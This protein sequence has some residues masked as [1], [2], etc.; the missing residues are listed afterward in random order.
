M[1]DQETL[2][3]LFK[4]SDGFLYWKSSNTNAVKAGGLAGS[5][6]SSGYLCVLVKNKLQLVHRV[7]FMMHNGYAPK[8]VDHIDGNPMNNKIENLRDAT[9]SQ[10]CWNSKTRT[11][12]SSG[13]KNVS[14]HSKS[15]KWLVRLRANGKE[16]YVGIFGD[17]E[18]ANKSAIEAR[19][20]YHGAFANHG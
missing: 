12:N 10:N 8:I 19:K 14:W 3:N 1:P 4:Y 5:K 18:D 20:K 6:S 11:T 16:V 15:K 17:I 2:L 13:F 9:K 7:I